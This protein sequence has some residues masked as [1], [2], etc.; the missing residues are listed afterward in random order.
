VDG[1]VFSA[2][3]RPIAFGA[4]KR[5]GVGSR[6]AGVREVSKTR[7]V[8]RLALRRAGEGDVGTEERQGEGAAVLV[9]QGDDVFRREGARKSRR[10]REDERERDGG[11]LQ[12]DE[13]DAIAHEGVVAEGAGRKIIP[14]VRKEMVVHMAGKATE[15]R[16][17]T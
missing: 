2:E 5:E 15:G 14:F 12:E 4:H 1:E 13:G 3:E 8:F 16:R 7:H 10:L 9:D 17:R 6:G 11:G